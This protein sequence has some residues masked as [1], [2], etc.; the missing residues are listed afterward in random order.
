MLSECLSL[1]RGHST[2]EKYNRILHHRAHASIQWHVVDRAHASIQWHVVDR[3]HAFI[4]L[5]SIPMPHVSVMLGLM[6]PFSPQ[7]S[8]TFRISSAAVFRVTGELLSCLRLLKVPLI[9]SLDLLACLRHPPSTLTR[10]VRTRCNAKRHLRRR[11]AS[12]ERRASSP[13]SQLRFRQAHKA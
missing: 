2:G 8:R 13:V 11:A 6:P 5:I 1:Y 7:Y 10:A 12:V 9:L 3:A 4:Q